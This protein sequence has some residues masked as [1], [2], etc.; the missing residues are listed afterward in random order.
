M[1]GLE[2]VLLRNRLAEAGFEPSVFRYPSTQAD[3]GE[4]ALSLAAHMRGFGD[5]PVHLVGHSLGGLVIL[6]A[7]GAPG[8]LPQGRVVL[9]GSPVQGSRAARAVAAW[10]LG[11]HLLG[12]LAAAELTRREPRTWRGERELGIIAGSRSAGMG[13]LFAN[14]PAPNDGTVSVDETRITGA[15]EHIV[16]D[17]SHTGMLMSAVVADSLV[18]FLN[19]GSFGS[20]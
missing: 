20:C 4:A 7:F 16:H 3:I 18:K 19:S 11:P 1:N 5:G 10:S 13:R 2:S 12:R 15:K 6:E 9:L 17:V 8:E 14:L